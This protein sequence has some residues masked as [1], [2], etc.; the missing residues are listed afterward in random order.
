MDEMDECMKW[1]ERNTC[2]SEM[3]ECMHDI[4]NEVKWVK[5]TNAWSVT[6]EWHE[7]NEWHTWNEW[8]IKGNGWN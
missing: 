3:G 8:M 7:M 1:Y 6:I 2:M 4:M 5:W